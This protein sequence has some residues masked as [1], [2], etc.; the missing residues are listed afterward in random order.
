MTRP[1]PE[2]LDLLSRP[3]WYDVWLGALVQWAI[4]VPLLSFLLALGSIASSTTN[5]LLYALFSPIYSAVVGAVVTV[6]LGVP[7]AKLLARILARNT[8]W[9]A[10]LIAFV[11]LGFILAALLLHLWM[12]VGGD[13]WDA[14]AWWAAM[15]IF[16]PIASAAALSVGAGWSIAWRRAVLRERRGA[17]ALAEDEL[18]E[19][20]A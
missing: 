10:H 5:G 3:T 1:G 19:A 7:L 17:G 12:L 15:P 4:F 6:A 9:I 18:A 13:L 16:F 20:D 14:S 2:A 11:G 8:Q